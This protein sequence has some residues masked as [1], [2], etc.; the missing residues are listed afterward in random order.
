MDKKD[1]TKEDDTQE[2]GLEVDRE[3]TSE[4]IVNKPGDT[5]G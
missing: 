5:D 4:I 3:T 1:D 2:G